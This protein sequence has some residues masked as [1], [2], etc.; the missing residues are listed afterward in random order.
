MVAH[1]T[2]YVEADTNGIRDAQLNTNR[3]IHA[4]VGPEIRE[5][6]TEV[7]IVGMSCRTAGGVNNLEKLWQLLLNKQ[8]ASGDV[9]QHRWEPWLRRDSR[10]K[11]Q[12]EKTISKGYF[13]ED[14]ENFDASFFGISPKEAEQMDPHQRLGLEL[15]WEALE[16]AGIDPKSLSGSD[17]AVYMGCDSDDYSRLLLEDI[18]NIEAWMGI[19]TA[20]HGIPNRISYHLDLMGPSA[21]VDAACASSL[22]AIHLGYQC[23]LNGESEV[24]IVG[25]VNVL[26]APALTRMLGKAG[27][28]SPEGICRSFDDAANGYA[29]GEGGAVVVLKK[30]TSA[31]ADGD[32]IFAVLKGSAIAQDG[33]TNGIMAPNTKA[34]ELVGRWALKRA[35]I[36]PLS[37]AYVEAHATSTPLGDPTE[38]SAIAALYGQGAGR[39]VDTPVYLGSIKP[40]VG[41][42]EAAAGAIG[43]VK[44]VLAI[45]NGQLAPQARLN[46]LNSRIDWENSGLHVVRDTMSWPKSEG[47][48]RAA[49]CCYGYGGTVSHAL[50]QEAP[51]CIFENGTNATGSVGSVILTLSSPQKKRL[52]EHSRRLAEWLSSPDGEKHSLSDI[53]NTL[54]QRRSHHDYRAAF[55]AE[56]REGVISALND[57]AADPQR[58]NHNT[59]Q[60]RVLGSSVDAR[61]CMIFSGH[62]AQYKAMGVELLQNT[63]FLRT[64]TGLDRIVQKE[65]GF[66]AVGSLQT[67]DFETADRVQILTYI[68]QIG[69]YDVLLSQ[70]LVPQAV[71][72]H[73]VG[74]IAASVVAGC[75]TRQEGL[76]IVTR[77]AKLYAQLR[78]EIS[79]A[80]SLVNLP[81]STV[82]EELRGREDLVVA[83]DSSPSTCVVSGEANSVAKY[84]EALKVRN[85]RTFRVNTD[86]PFHSPMLRPYMKALEEALEGAVFPRHATL[87]LYSTSNSDPRTTVLRDTEYWQTNTV[88]PVLLKSAVN[89]AADD[90]YRIFIEVSSHPIVLNSV[91]DTLVDKGLSDEDFITIH[92]MKRDSSALASIPK[93][94]ANAYT[95]G[96]AVNFE[97]QFGHKRKWCREVPGTPW[98]HKPYYRQVEVD[99]I[100]K[101]EVHDV[102]KH[103]LLGHRTTVAST[104]TVIFSTKLDDRTKPY[105]GRHPL[106]G[107]EIIPAAVYINTFYHSTPVGAASF[108]DIQL[109][110]PVSMGPDTR[111]VQI[112]VE[113]KSIRV[114]ST[115]DAIADDTEQTWVS[116]SSANWAQEK[117]LDSLS[118]E[119]IEIRAI[120]E[121]I[122][123]ILPNN[124]ATDY[125]AKIGVEGI[126]FPWQVIEHFGNSKEMMVKVDMDPSV[127][128]LPWDEYSWA[129]LLDAATSVGS[130]IFFND[131]KLKIV[132]GI[133]RVD[134]YSSRP[135]PKIGY[136]FIEDS[137]DAKNPAAHV[138]VLDE[139]GLQL[140]KFTSMRFSEV[141]GAQGVSSGID[142]LA[143]RIAWVPPKFSETARELGD[144]VLVSPNFGRFSEQVRPHAKTLF[145]ASSATQIEDEAEKVVS[146]LSKNGSTIIFIPREVEALDEVPSAAE[147]IIWEAATLVKFLTDHSLACKFYIITNSVQ[148]GK[149]ATGL[150]HAPLQGLSRIIGSEHPDIWGCLIDTDTDVVFPLTAIK[151]VQGQDVL[152]MVDGLP[153]RPIMRPFTREYLHKPDSPKKILPSPEGTYLITGGLGDLGLATCEFLIKKGARRIVLVSRRGLPPRSQWPQLRVE[154]A[155]LE[156]I[157]EQ[158][159]KFER[160]G[161]AIHPLAVD[162]ASA[163]AADLLLATLD[164]LSLPPVLG[165][166]HAAGVFG[167]SLLMETTRDDYANVFAPKIDGQLIGTEGQAA[168]A[169]GNAFLDGLATYRRARG[170]NTFSFQFTAWLGLGLVRDLTFFDDELRSKGVTGIT[171][172]E[173][174]CAWEHVSKFDAEGAVITRIRSIEEGDPAPLPILEDV[175]V[176]KVTA[177]TSNMPICPSQGQ[178]PGSVPAEKADRQQWLTTKIRECIAAVL[179]ISDI[180]EIDIRKPLSDFGVDSVMTF[181]LRQKLQMT[182]KVKVPAT[183]TWNHPTVNHLVAWFQSSIKD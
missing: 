81:Y 124:F 159:E 147:E 13:I 80:M 109:R 25:G 40:N 96:A 128:A 144:V 72:G 182:F 44:A 152:R 56:T 148:S 67:G 104:D 102:E 46:K 68:I 51:K 117:N 10:N 158:I 170:D 125:L 41:H 23:I 31:V 135:P 2:S 156:G 103:T 130:A 127:Q 101:V 140:A 167:G 116:H 143:H 132:S 146:V 179:M 97:A 175:V 115:A 83:I 95:A 5:L 74:E 93:A 21:A 76:L 183:L 136:L 60:R 52:F 18:P 32:K 3:R 20:A 24:A 84:V 69:L 153:R 9:P 88:Y 91:D 42:L 99:A 100:G 19:G 34:Q 150:A 64:V 35:G 106:D 111:R 30:L 174:F 63:T 22:V 70:G 120:Q 168:Y 54:A 85:I 181:V 90:G 17:T 29:R 55:V 58:D 142:G 43:L 12:L 176:R 157:I 171:P 180:D 126:A 138:T 7:A 78:S 65:A 87:P 45:N 133:D 160:L 66:S 59:V 53:A 131:I 47:P 123:T 57:F 71:I 82:A 6:P 94:I 49:V 39:G 14:L 89:A 92:T 110:V 105:P 121:R 151:Y 177:R 134:I 163:A 149:T 36:D 108:T 119:K 98:L 173:A 4:A 137:S 27:A 26:L 28:L 61:V 73:S 38:V 86:V 77:R 172:D 11:K 113:G 139:E 166:I 107:T 155:R 15:A 114:A 129:P 33:K 122:G 118:Q 169:S 62:G 164:Q 48:K 141:E 50:I 1:S 37:V 79:G 145:Q 178:D 162:V 161:A 8:D 154:D 16:N 165:I 75:L 112:I